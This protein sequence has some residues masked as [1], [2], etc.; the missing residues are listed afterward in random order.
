MT[1]ETKSRIVG[2]LL[3]TTAVAI[4]AYQLGWAHWNPFTPEAWAWRDMLAVWWLVPLLGTM[5]VAS[6][7]ISVWVIYRTKHPKASQ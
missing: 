6:V 7:I 3:G 4:S 2:S 1:K 5:I